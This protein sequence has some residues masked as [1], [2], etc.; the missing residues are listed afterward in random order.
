MVA[1]PRAAHRSPG[2]FRRAGI[3]IL[4]RDGRDCE[5]DRPP[6]PVDQSFAPSAPRTRHGHMYPSHFWH[7]GRGWSVV[8]HPLM[9]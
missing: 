5:S 9:S 7:W 2:L 3:S 1:P 4:L 8:I 6:V